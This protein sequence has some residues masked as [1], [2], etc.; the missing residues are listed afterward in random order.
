MGEGEL[1]ACHF[2]EFSVGEADTECLSVSPAST[3]GCGPFL[4]VLRFNV[5]N[6]LCICLFLFIQITYE[7]IN[8]EKMNTLQKKFL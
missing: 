6:I 2:P 4:R 5:V 7:Y 3:I 1:G 8:I